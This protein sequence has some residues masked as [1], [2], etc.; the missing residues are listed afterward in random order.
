MDFNVASATFEQRVDVVENILSNMKVRQ[1]GGQAG[2]LLAGDPGVGK[3]SFIRFFSRLIGVHLITIEAP[4][5]TEEHII[6]IPFI[7]FNPTNGQQTSGT[8][9]L[10]TTDYKIVLS[11]SNLFTQIN[12]TGK[13]SDSEYL[14]SIYKSPKDVIAVF[15]ELGGTQDTIPPIIKQAR[16]RFNVVL[17]L[18]EYFRQTSVR[19]RNMLRGI[20]NGKIGTHDVPPGAYVIYASNI[21]DEGVDD[22]PANQ[23][24]QT[25][26]FSTPNKT[27]WFS[28]LVNKF[29]NDTKVKLNKAVISKFYQLLSDE[30]LNNN[31]INAEVR[32]SPRRWEQLLL[33]I[34]AS[35]PPE[36]Q[37]DADGLITN[38]KIN[39]KNYLTGE[40]AE[41]Y[42]K[43]VDAVQEL[44]DDTSE[45]SAG[46]EHQN[47]EWRDTL[48][49][50]IKQKMKLGEHRK[51]IPIISGMPGIGKTSQAIQVATDLNLRYI[52][53]D[54]STL[55][56][57]DV[58]GIPLSKKGKKDEME[59]HF[60]EPKLYRQII[61]EAKKLDAQY[62]SDS[63][64][65]ASD[66]KK[67]E[68]KYLIFFDELNRTTTKVFNGIRK[69]ILE[70]NFGGDYNLPDGSVVIAAINPKD[71]GAEQLTHHMRDVVDV[72]DAESSWEATK[73]YIENIEIPDVEE[74]TTEALASVIFK[75]ANKF[76]DNDAGRKQS[77]R[78]FYLN[79]GGGDV[80]IS[81]REYTDMFKN[82]C[83]TFQHKFDRLTRKTPTSEMEADELK[84]LEQ[85]L[86]KSV[87][88]SL[89]HTLT[90]IFTKYG[91]HNPEFFHNLEAWIM[92]S[93]EVDFGDGIFYRKVSTA[94]L[95][96]ILEKYYDNEEHDLSEDMEFIN[97]MNNNDPQKFSE[98][99]TSF[100]YNKIKDDVESHLVAEP[101]RKK[102][103]SD[104]KTMTLIDEDVSKAE[105]FIR[106][107]VHTT[108]VHEMSNDKKEIIKNAIINTNK[109]LRDDDE[110]KKL[111]MPKLLNFNREV[112]LLIKGIK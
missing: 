94:G 74:T 6:N 58:T 33:Y 7:V 92:T 72:I 82:M 62:L 112:L 85:K 19:I 106:S 63:G 76:R 102:K 61:E 47:H 11:D 98:D 36:S 41:L 70:K 9:H 107:L 55:D 45:F 56:A 38:V 59:V 37:K 64:V 90:T 4:H 91:V 25:I 99:L 75:F 65:K 48:E 15:E 8:Q 52:Y 51:Y 1:M 86:R 30:E 40:H 5:I 84:N 39:F 14:D 13:I 97:Y 103:I 69:V 29:E 87:F 10:D 49:H 28:W 78:E 73:E 54:C 17:F 68:W 109:R 89:K 44:I 80:Y 93:P 67:Q 53:V 20:L 2:I 34:N 27:D 71:H 66:Y 101:G 23:D 43:V 83:V 21:N 46:H 60:S 50:Q 77:Q 16:D 57:E 110:I 79:V 104:G 111:H 12:R 105:N 32:T 31:D 95:E 18:D 88:D 35:I 24:F 81:P 100:M 26:E 22:I 3:T 108:Q 96:E 42:K